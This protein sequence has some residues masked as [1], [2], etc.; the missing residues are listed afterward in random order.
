MAAPFEII[1]A[2][3]EVWVS[4]VGTAFP[5]ID[6]APASTWTR[7][8]AN[9]AYNYA[10][11]GITVTHEQTVNAWRGLKGTGPIKAFRTE[12]GLMLGFTLH[13]LRLEQ[14]A[15]AIN[16]SIL[17]VADT[18][19]GS[20]VAGFRTLKLHQGPNMK[21]LAL[22][23]RGKSPYDDDNWN[24]QYEVPKVFQ[25]ANP[26]PVHRKGEPAGLALVFTAMEDLNAAT[27]DDRFGVL[28]AQDA[29]PL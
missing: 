6:V 25:S 23:C 29:A 18:A 19:P 5:L 2:P 15:Y 21:F 20:G 11:E 24:M 1:A 27:E 28:R 9:G 26:T 22:L 12:E 17:D 10:S 16:R 14:Y 13:D 7:L 4:P 8:G 3:F